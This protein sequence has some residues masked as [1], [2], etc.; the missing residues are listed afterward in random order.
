MN[1]EIFMTWLNVFFIKVTDTVVIPVFVLTG[2]IVG[3]TIIQ[4]G[5]TKL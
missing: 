3:N 5:I 1:D 2:G 4:I